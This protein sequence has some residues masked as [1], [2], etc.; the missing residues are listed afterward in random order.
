MLRVT[1]GV[2]PCASLGMVPDV[3]GMAA[4]DINSV[5]TPGC[6]LFCCSGCSMLCDAW[7]EPMCLFGHC[8]RCALH[9]CPGHE[10]REYTML[11]DLSCR[12]CSM[13]CVTPGVN[14]CASLGMVPDVPGMT[15]LDMNSVSTPPAACL[16]VERPLHPFCVMP[17]AQLGRRMVGRWT[18]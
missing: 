12:G 13:L 18:A 17:G 8:V 2:N 6:L 9:G 10:L 15:A 5:S 7:C 11:V 3:L 1:P 4:L 14:L 16:A